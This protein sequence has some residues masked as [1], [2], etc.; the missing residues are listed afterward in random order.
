MRL[1]LTITCFSL[2]TNYY[3]VIESI[4]AFYFVNNVVVYKVLLVQGKGGKL[5]YKTFIVNVV[6]MHLSAA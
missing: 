1:K 2:G 3:F 6:S 4:D 5:V